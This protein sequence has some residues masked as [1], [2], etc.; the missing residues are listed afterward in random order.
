MNQLP[1]SVCP[2]AVTA[3]WGEFPPAGRLPLGMSVLCPSLLAA[4]LA[5]PHP[6]APTRLSLCLGL[7]CCPTHACSRAVFLDPPPC[8]EGTV[9]SVKFSWDRRVK[10]LL[11]DSQLCLT[12]LCV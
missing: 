6:A 10:G 7:H 8:F 4:S 3:P 12:G 9:L 1:V 11:L 2:E 5:C